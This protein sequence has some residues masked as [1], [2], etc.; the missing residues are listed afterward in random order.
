MPRFQRKPDAAPDG[1]WLDLR[2]KRTGKL[3]A[4][5]NVKAMVLEIKRSDRELVAYFDLHE[6]VLLEIKTDIE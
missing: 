2:D 5:L 3:C 6:Y 1:D 4:R